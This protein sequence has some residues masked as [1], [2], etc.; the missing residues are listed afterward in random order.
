MASAFYFRSLPA[1]PAVVVSQKKTKKLS[2]L[3]S[4]FLRCFYATHTF[5]FSVKTC[6]PCLPDLRWCLLVDFRGLAYPV[7]T[8]RLP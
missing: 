2:F 3:H 1:Q 7:F 8:N 4:I 6:A 5:Q